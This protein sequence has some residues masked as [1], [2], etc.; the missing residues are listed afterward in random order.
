MIQMV[1]S[2]LALASITAFK[3]M[4]MTVILSLNQKLPARRKGTFIF[5]QFTHCNSPRW[6]CCIGKFLYASSIEEET[7]PANPASSSEGAPAERPTSVSDDVQMENSQSATTFVSITVISC[8][9]LQ[10]VKSI[11]CCLPEVYT[12][13]TAQ[14]QS[15]NSS[16]SSPYTLSHSAFCS[17]GQFIFIQ[18]KRET[19]ESTTN[20]APVVVSYSGSGSI[21]SGASSPSST[22]TSWWLE[23]FDPSVIT[24][25][26]AKHIKSLELFG[27]MPESTILPAKHTP[28]TSDPKGTPEPAFTA[29]LFE[30][31]YPYATP[32]QY[33]VMCP[34][35]ACSSTTDFMGRVFSLD[36]G[37][38]LWDVNMH[39]T[40]FGKCKLPVNL[41]H[42]P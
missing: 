20:P 3:V 9:T 41:T 34:P 37:K 24:D 12:T 39:T 26:T 15:S 31:G 42:T 21:S 25:E 27:P 22:K 7:T 32:M 23:V 28:K 11:K 35:E 16:S 40:P 5:N 17:D 29:Q 6:L 36:T 14:K 38:H 1:S 18:T 30:K 8:D 2:R 10:V 4:S 19:K 13:S 33:V